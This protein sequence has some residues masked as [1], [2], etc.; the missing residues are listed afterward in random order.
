[1]LCNYPNVLRKPETLPSEYSDTTSPKCRKLL[2]ADDDEDA[3]TAAAE[4]AAAV[5]AAATAAA[6]AKEGPWPPPGD[7]IIVPIV[8]KLYTAL[9]LLLLLQYA[10]YDEPIHYPGKLWHW[11]KSVSMIESNNKYG[12]ANV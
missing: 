8:F 2:A 11:K 6:V 1:M 5:A 4:D 10:V 3:A 7:I 12:R 9:G